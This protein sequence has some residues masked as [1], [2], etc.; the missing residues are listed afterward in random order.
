MAAVLLVSW[1][2]VG[3]H[4]VVSPGLLWRTWLC[5]HVRQQ[6]GID[7]AVSLFCI[8]MAAALLNTAFR[9]RRILYNVR[10]SRAIWLGAAVDSYQTTCKM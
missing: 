8:M 4:Q 5:A 10:V 7:F 1:A 9:Q 2:E 3:Q 6:A